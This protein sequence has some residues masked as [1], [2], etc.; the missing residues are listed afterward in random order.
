MCS[1]REAL[2]SKLAEHVLHR[3]VAPIMVGVR[4]LFVLMVVVVVSLMKD[5]FGCPA[6]VLRG[7]VSVL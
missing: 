7:K 2:L 5:P 1:R 6:D 3:K 4:G